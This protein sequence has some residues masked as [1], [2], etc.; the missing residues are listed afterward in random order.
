MPDPHQPF[1]YDPTPA[2]HELASRTELPAR[3]QGRF[4]FQEAH[5]L[6]C[7]W[8]SRHVAEDMATPQPVETGTHLEDL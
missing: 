1:Q 2:D 4:S 8:N 5:L 3:M 7:D 6:A